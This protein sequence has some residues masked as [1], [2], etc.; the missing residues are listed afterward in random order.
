MVWAFVIVLAKKRLTHA[1]ILFALSLVVDAFSIALAGIYFRGQAGRL[2]IYDYLLE[3]TVILA[4]P[5]YYIS[6]CA[7]TEPRGATL[8]QRH[9]FIIPLL[10]IMGLTIGAFGMHPS[11]YQAMCLQVIDTGHIPWIA[12]DFAYNYMV[13]WNQIVFPV[14]TIVMGIILLVVSERKIRLY[15]QRF[16]SYYAH[17]LHMPHLNIREIVIISWLYLPFG[18]L[19]IYL[20][21]FRPYYYKY[22][23]IL[24][25]LMLTVIQHLTG[26]FAF[27]YNLDARFLANYVRNKQ[28]LNS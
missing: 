1:Q 28:P 14:V 13:L 19:T 25:S 16:D 4:A 11:R 26:R 24:S 8:R 17:D 20:I 12:G 2:Y 22:W 23:L 18:M 5:M 15:K 9:V 6:V 10:F 27:R 7:L 3:S 21:A